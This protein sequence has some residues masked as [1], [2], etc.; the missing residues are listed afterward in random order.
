VARDV[1]RVFRKEKNKLAIILPA[2]NEAKV[3]GDIIKSIPKKFPGVTERVVVV[4]D[5]NSS[6]ETGIVAR[7]A[8]AVV[9]RH[10]L[11][12]G[13]GGATMTGLEYAKRQGF[14]VAVTLDADGQHD[15]ADIKK[16]LKKVHEGY[17]FVIGSRL[18][19][20][21]NLKDMPRIKRFGN[22]LFSF[23][24]YLYYRIWISDSQSG[25]KAFSKKAIKQC[26][27][28]N[29]G[30]EFCSEM[31]GRAKANKLKI[32]EVPIKT[33]Y[34]DYSK[35]KGQYYLNGFNIVIKMTLSKLKGNL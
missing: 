32:C 30:Y 15:P 19:E 1:K 23:I 27:I 16:L 5:D 18:I 21:N 3:I 33:I 12:L 31:I 17:D 24:T 13:A 2:Y 11:N 10:R 25:F 6:D 34:T 35:I 8:K 7:R 4:V 9:L 29:V 26:Q 28:Q 14:D 22:R 20:K